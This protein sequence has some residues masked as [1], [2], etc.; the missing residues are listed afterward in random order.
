MSKRLLIF[1]LSMSLL[2][3]LAA[4][5]GAVQDVQET[6]ES[7][8]TQ[9]GPTLEAVVTDVAP[10]VEAAATSIAGGDDDGFPDLDGREVRI[11]VENA[12][13]PFSFINEE[14][15]AVGY[16]YD[17]FAEICQRV[18]CEPVF[19]ETSW[20]AM[21]AIMGGE[22]GFDTFDI[23]ADGITITEER[24]QNVDFSDPYIQLAQVLLVRAGEDRFTSPDEFA[25]DEELLIGTQ[26]GTTNYDTAAELV[27]DSRI[28]AYDQFGLAVQALINGDVDA[29]MMDDVAGLGYVGANPDSVMIV[30]EPLTSEELGF[31]FPKGGDLVEPVNMALAQMAEDGTL[32]MLFERWFQTEDESVAAGDLPDLDGREVRIA[33]EN[34]YNPFSFINEEGEAVGYD[35]DIFA[36][37]CQR[38]NCEPVFVET[39]WDAMVAIMGGEGGFDTFD[40]GADGITIT[41]ERAQNV[42]FSDP[43]IQLAQVLL[44]R[45][46]EDRFTSPDEFAAD[47][48]LLIGTQPGTT[49]YDTAA[50]LVGDS[51]IVAYDQF[52]LAVQALINGDVDA[53]MMDDVA[54]LGYVGANPDSVMIVEEPLTSEELGFIFPKGGDLVEPVNMALAQMA[55]DGTLDMLFE[56]WFQTEETE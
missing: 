1:V 56:R 46:G 36:E 40:I 2:L 5:T 33:V 7:A 23:G 16:D 54:G 24:A 20:D 32:D 4:C 51:R 6:V 50:E 8:A 17:I 38:V 13:N 34:A 43:Y 10:T 9:I 49:N 30:E 42:D 31:I 28:V 15:E 45:A 37:I 29:V 39:S 44:V 14:G 3:I 52:G 47:E 19:V 22:G 21:V 48:E 53:V 41:E 18:N 12:Y 55:E 11:A 25:A 26:P 35:Y 27:G